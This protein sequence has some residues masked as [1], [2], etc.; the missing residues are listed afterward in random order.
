MNKACQVMT[1]VSS[2]MIGSKLL[3]HR[4]D[5]SNSLQTTILMNMELKKMNFNSNKFKREGVTIQ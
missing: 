1:V 3:I 4:S 2:I 5:T